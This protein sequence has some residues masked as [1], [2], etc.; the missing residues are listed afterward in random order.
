MSSGLSVGSRDND[1]GHGHRN[2]NDDSFGSATSNG[3]QLRV[4]GRRIG[5]GGDDKRQVVS[6]RL[7]IGGSVVGPANAKRSN[8]LFSVTNHIISVSGSR[9]CSGR[10]HLGKDIHVWSV[11]CWN[12]GEGH[13]RLSRR[14][15]GELNAVCVG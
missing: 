11:A 6:I 9:G 12:I 4:G 7:G 8:Q 13:H 3:G 10:N 14:T 15:L 5:M 1:S 2:I